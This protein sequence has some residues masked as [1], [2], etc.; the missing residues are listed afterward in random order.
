M[1]FYSEIVFDEA[2]GKFKEGRA[3]A[4]FRY[5]IYEGNDHSIIKLPNDNNEKMIEFRKLP[6]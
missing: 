4:G 1:F 3:I 2:I 5:R 6:C